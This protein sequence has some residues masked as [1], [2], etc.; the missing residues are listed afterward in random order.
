MNSRNIRQIN[1]ISGQFNHGYISNGFSPINEVFNINDS[2]TEVYGSSDAVFI[3]EGYMDNPYGMF[4]IVKIK[5]L[6]LTKEPEGGGVAVDFDNYIDWDNSYFLLGNEDSYFQW[7]LSNP[8]IGNPVKWFYLPLFTAQQIGVTGIYLQEG[9]FSEFPAVFNDIN[10]GLDTYGNSKFL[11]AFDGKTQSNFKHELGVMDTKTLMF[12]G[13]FNESSFVRTDDKITVGLNRVLVK[14][15]LGEIGY[16][17]V[18]ELNNLYD[19]QSIFAI[20]ES[21]IIKVNKRLV[22]GDGVQKLSTNFITED[23]LDEI[24]TTNSLIYGIKRGKINILDNYAPF[25]RE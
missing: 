1:D 17:Q 25:P 7:N 21:N 24:D 13:K 6:V 8:D 9:C 16:D 10:E 20:T 11:K 19:N 5:L 14:Q 22:Y 4:S 3:K 12:W 18:I 23:N 15:S 2:G